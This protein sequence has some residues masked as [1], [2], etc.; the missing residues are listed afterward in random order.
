MEARTPPSELVLVPYVHEL[1]ESALLAF[2]ARVLGDEV[3]RKR[4]L[5]LDAIH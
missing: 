1:H 5:V 2:L 4:R 3:C